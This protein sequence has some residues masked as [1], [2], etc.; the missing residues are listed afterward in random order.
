MQ[1]I[2]SIQVNPSVSQGPLEKSSPRVKNIS[3]G[4]DTV[5]WDWSPNHSRGILRA[6]VLETD[7]LSLNPSLAT[8]LPTCVTLGKLLNFSVPQFVIY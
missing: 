1:D 4:M 5:S 2:N 3:N 6:S 8:Y 7:C